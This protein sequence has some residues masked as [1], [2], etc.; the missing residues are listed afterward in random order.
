M[1]NTRLKLFSKA[2]SVKQSVHFVCCSLRVFLLFV[3]WWSMWVV[4]IYGYNLL[5]NFIQELVRALILLD[6][7]HI[8]AVLR[9]I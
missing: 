7:L 3:F 2:R 6:P 5:L 4:Q 8:K 9:I 1:V